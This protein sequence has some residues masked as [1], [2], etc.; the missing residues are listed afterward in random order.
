M[1]ARRHLLVINDTPEILALFVQIFEAEGYRVTTDRF[2]RSPGELLE[3]IKAQ[4]PDLL[5]LDFLIGGEDTGWQLLQLLKM[6]RATHGIRTIVCTA[7]RKQIE[8]LRSH[9]DTLGVAAVLKPFDIDDLLATVAR[10]WDQD[11][12]A[13]KGQAAAVE[14]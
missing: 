1:A 7:A 6:D 4:A 14:P 5:I 2:A 8:E 3:A 12:A 13:A 9:L 10:V 11:A